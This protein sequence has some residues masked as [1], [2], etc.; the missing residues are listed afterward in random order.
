MNNLALALEPTYTLDVQT[1][2]A[3]HFIIVGAGGTGGYLIPNMFRQ[4]SLQNRLL[5]LESKAI[6]TI[7]IIEGDAVEDKNLTRQNFL[8]RDVGYNKGEIMANRYGAAFGLEV[9][10]IPEYLENE[11]M[12]KDVIKNGSG[13]PVLIDCVDN[14]ATRMIIHNVHKATKGSFYL[15]S[16][17]EEWAGQVIC[18]YNA[19]KEFEKGNKAPHLFNLPDIAD[20]YPEVL[21][22]EE[23]LPTELS[24][25]ERAVSNPQ[26]IQT[27]MTAANLLMNFANQIL[28]SNTREGEG[29]TA[30]QVVFN[31][32]TPSFSTT[33]N[34]AR[35]LSPEVEE[36]KVEVEVEV[37][38]TA[39]KKAVKKKEEEATA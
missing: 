30:H 32:Q 16:G 10:Y 1:K 27:N 19:G 14:N 37:K 4:I 21:N 9:N 33:L 2:V 22:G 34:K 35:F 20:I 11:K 17:N 25:A 28:T 5:R 8:Q 6:H 31:T 29:I 26:N 18:G 13:I 39:K 36:V 23:K 38:K 24:C 12:L 15:S 3:K 7:T